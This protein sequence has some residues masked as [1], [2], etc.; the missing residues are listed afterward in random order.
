MR[1]SRYIY[2]NELNKSCFQ[3]D[4]AYG[5][6]KYLTRRTASDKILRHKAFN[7]AKNPKCDWY[8]RGLALMVYKFLDKKSSCSGIKNEN[9]SHKKLAEELH[10]PIIRKF[11]KRKVLSSFVDNICGADLANMQLISKFNKWIHFLLSVINIFSKYAWVFPLR[12]KDDITITNAFQLQLQLL[13]VL[14]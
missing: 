1:D 7:T 9:I 13:K 8:H 12:E 3:H 10:R 11:N 6:F 4:I 14:K 5:D 2:Q